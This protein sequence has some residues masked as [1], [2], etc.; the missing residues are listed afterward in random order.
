ML[1]SLAA[2]GGAT[3]THAL[4]P[5]SPAIDTGNNAS[6]LDFDQRGTGFPRF[7]GI[8]TD[9]GAFEVQPSSGDRIFTNGFDP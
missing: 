3:L 2:N 9:I 1:A 5:E 8:A 6:A 7:A 4:L